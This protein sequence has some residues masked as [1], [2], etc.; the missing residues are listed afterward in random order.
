MVAHHH[1]LHYR[2]NDQVEQVSFEG[3]VN[4]TLRRP[5]GERVL[6]TNG[7]HDQL[8]LTQTELRLVR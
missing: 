1:K 7:P 3:A 4:G 5:E 2:T 6:T 8:W